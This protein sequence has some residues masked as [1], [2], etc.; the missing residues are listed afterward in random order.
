[1]G[2]VVGFFLLFYFKLVRVWLWYSWCDEENEQE[3]THVYVDGGRK[4][5]DIEK[6][7]RN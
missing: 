3:A 7:V 4:N 2:S 6:L 5:D 1:M